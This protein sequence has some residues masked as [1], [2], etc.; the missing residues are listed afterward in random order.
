[1]SPPRVEGHN[2][3]STN[4]GGDDIQPRSVDAREFFA[5]PEFDAFGDVPAEFDREGAVVRITGAGAA[6]G[7]IYEHRGA[8]FEGPLAQA[9]DQID[10]LNSA[11]VGQAAANQVLQVAANGDD[12]EFIDSGNIAA[13]ADKI[14]GESDG[15]RME[16]GEVTG[17]PGAASDDTWA[18]NDFVSVD[19][20]FEEEFGSVPGVVIGAASGVEVT[21]MWTNRSTTGIRIH[22]VNYRS[23]APPLAAVVPWIAIGPD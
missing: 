14:V 15:L 18:T 11:D 16:F 7:G 6:A 23:D 2:H 1:M 20:T 22:I 10:A 4:E 19:V 17:Q 8:G 9:T 12:L 5:P 3:G 21:S 13:V